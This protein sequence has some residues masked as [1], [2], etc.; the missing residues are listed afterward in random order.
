MS[1]KSN[2]KR[3]ARKSAERGVQI[4]RA[5]YRRAESLS[6][7]DPESGIPRFT[8]PAENLAYEPKGPAREILRRYSEAS[9]NKKL[10][11][12]PHILALLFP[13]HEIFKTVYSNRSYIPEIVLWAAWKP[14]ILVCPMCK[15]RITL[16]GDEENYRCDGCSNFAETLISWT[17]IIPGEDGFPAL[18]CHMGLCKSCAE[19]SGMY[20]HD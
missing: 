7:V 15:E 11:P 5:A 13:E 19:L 10:M 20:S 8:S 12:C 6:P 14:D 16:R 3:A 17:S 2:R 4:I 1:R 9:A 18:A